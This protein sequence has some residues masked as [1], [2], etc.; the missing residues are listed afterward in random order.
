VRGT[1]SAALD[2]SALL[3]FVRREPGASIVESL[4]GQA[5]MSAV[6][7]A[8]VAQ[9][10]EASGRD[11]AAVRQRVE[12]LGVM[13]IPFTARDGDR[14]GSVWLQTRIAGLSL[15]GRACLAL[16]AREGIPALTA[17]RTWTTLDLGIEVRL[18]R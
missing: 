3:A 14:V 11:A 17:D 9:K 13:V 18:I 4:I 2:S 15:G 6:N 8:E 1:F 10:L 16:A 5:V 7:W 12:N